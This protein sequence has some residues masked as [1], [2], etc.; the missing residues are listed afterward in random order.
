MICLDYEDNI[1]GILERIIGKEQ[2]G[3]WLMWLMC[4]LVI[5]VLN[6]SRCSKIRVILS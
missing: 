4:L 3:M 5:R 2:G 6:R 1:F